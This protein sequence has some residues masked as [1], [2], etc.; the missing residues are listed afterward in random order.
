MALS[1][2]TMWVKVT[3]LHTFVKALSLRII[4]YF[5]LSYLIFILLDIS[6]ANVNNNLTSMLQLALDVLKSM[7]L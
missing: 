3:T 7:G 6:Y 4:I 5:S 2:L 1:D